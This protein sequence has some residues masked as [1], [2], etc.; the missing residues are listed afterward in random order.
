MGGNTQP[1]NTLT[2]FNGVVMKIRFGFVSNSS[3]SSFIIAVSPT[4]CVDVASLVE[5]CCEYDTEVAW[6]DID[7]R[8]LQLEEGV[9]KEHASCWQRDYDR[10]EIENLKDIKRR[11]P[12]KQLLGIS[13]SY[14]GQIV[15]ILRLL[16]TTGNIQIVS[17]DD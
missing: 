11:Y 12:N 3:S 5:N 13:V 9:L 8:I 10:D 14:H 6:S 2:A 17:Q 1:P 16:D 15:N 7:A 4:S